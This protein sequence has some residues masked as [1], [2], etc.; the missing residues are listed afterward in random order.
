M[1]P[2]NIRFEYAANKKRQ[3]RVIVCEAFPNNEGHKMAESL[4]MEEISVV[5]V[6]DSHVFGLMARV[7]KVKL[8]SD[9]LRIV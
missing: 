7:N 8:P 9:Q 2:R 5:L 4:A 1:P 3:F 6:P